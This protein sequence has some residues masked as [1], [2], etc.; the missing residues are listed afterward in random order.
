MVDCLDGFIVFS[1]VTVIYYY[2]YGLE[3]F[4]HVLWPF[5][6]VVLRFVQMT[7]LADV[8]CISQGLQ[9]DLDAARMASW[10]KRKTSQL[11]GWKEACKK[12]L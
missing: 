12:L 2:F 6:S 10:P 4:Q 9:E 3:V 7:H 8:Q 11:F 5:H 1:V